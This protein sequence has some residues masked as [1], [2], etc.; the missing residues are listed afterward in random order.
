MGVQDGFCYDDAKEGQGGDVV[1]ERW[2][3]A[4]V[5][6]VGLSPAGF[7]QQRPL[8]TDDAGLLETGMIRASLG[9]EFL[10][11]QRYSL[12]GLRGDLT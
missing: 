10:Q 5:I 12:S 4:L 11:G 9:I 7:G 6:L 2:M 8:R 3:L 1:I